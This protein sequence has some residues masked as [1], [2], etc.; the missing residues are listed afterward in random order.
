MVIALVSTGLTTSG[1]H[2]MVEQNGETALGF[3]LEVGL[4]LSLAFIML[5]LGIGLVPADF[6]RVIERGKPFLIGASCQIV[7]LPIVAFV[8]IYIFRLEGEIAAG[9]MLLSFCPGGVTSNV[10]SKLARGDVAL[11]VS[12]TALVSLLSIVTV[13][14]LVAWSVGYFM[15]TDAPPISVASLAIAMFLITALPVALGMIIRVLAPGFVA[16]IEKLFLTIASVLFVLIIVAAV[17]ANWSTL[18]ANFAALGPATMLLVALMLSLGLTIAGAS[19]LTWQER[20]TVA[21]EAGIQNGTLGITLAP[22]VV[23]GSVGLPAMALPSAIYGIAMYVVTIPFVIWLR[24][25]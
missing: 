20:K 25:K 11:S 1:H 13:P 18:T 17:A 12:L 8:L 9:F 23:A 2:D 10:I 7:L 19:G 24:G 16:R 14:I 6:K 5:T 3:L 22:L 21:I 15:G 4:P